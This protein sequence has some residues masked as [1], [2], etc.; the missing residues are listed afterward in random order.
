MIG[1]LGLG[2]TGEKSEFDGFPLIGDQRF[3]RGTDFPPAFRAEEKV[4]G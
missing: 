4:W 3:Q 2:M 1:Y